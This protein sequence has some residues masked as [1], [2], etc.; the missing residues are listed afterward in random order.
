MGHSP[1]KSLINTPL[2]I[3]RSQ[4]TPKEKR[5]RSTRGET[6]SINSEKSGTQ[7]YMTDNEDVTATV[8]A[9]GNATIIELTQEVSPH[10]FYTCFIL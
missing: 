3:K 10:L 9:N 8:I 2:S 5:R 6:T 1:S 4:K 7:W